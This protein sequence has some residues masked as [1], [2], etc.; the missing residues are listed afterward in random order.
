MSTNTGEQHFTLCSCCGDLLVS[1]F[2]FLKAFT[3]C[4]TPS[5]PTRSS[6]LLPVAFHDK[7]LIDRVLAAPQQACIH[8]AVA[9]N[10]P[11]SAFSSPSGKRCGLIARAT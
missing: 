2:F 7:Q 10:W 3:Q 1:F 4:P 8:A 6:S 11:Y 9:T 5:P